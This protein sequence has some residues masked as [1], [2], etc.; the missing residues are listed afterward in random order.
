VTGPCAM[1]RPMM[2]VAPLFLNGGHVHVRG[3]PRT[4]IASK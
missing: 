3:E 4:H 1:P 2:A